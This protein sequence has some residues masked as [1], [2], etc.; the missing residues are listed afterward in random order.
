MRATR[1]VGPCSNSFLSTSSW[2]ACA[3]RSRVKRAKEPAAAATTATM[4]LAATSRFFPDVSGTG[5]LR[6]AAALR[7]ELLVE[8]LGAW[9]RLPQMRVDGRNEE[10]RD[11][12]RHQQTS[13]DRAAQRGILLTTLADRQRHWDHSEHHGQR[14]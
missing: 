7:G 4:L 11:E 2:R 1:T 5:S 8:L 3:D 13:D 6:C 10:Q 12:R 9:R 14:S